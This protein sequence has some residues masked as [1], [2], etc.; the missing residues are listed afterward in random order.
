MAKR[1]INTT[2]GCLVDSLV[3][4]PYPERVAEIVKEARDI[5]KNKDGFDKF[6]APRAMLG[7]IAEDIIPLIWE[8]IGCENC[9][10]YDGEYIRVQLGNM[11]FMLEAI[12][13][14]LGIS[15]E[16]CI[17]KSEIQICKEP[18]KEAHIEMMLRMMTPFKDDE[19]NED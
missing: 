8:K 11:E 17:S 6:Q 9:Q 18:G 13:Q 10:C 4:T 5:A 12:R 3:I 1:K 15:R 2:S 14:E 7:V 16:D 19:E